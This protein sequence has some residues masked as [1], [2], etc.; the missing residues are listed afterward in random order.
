MLFLKDPYTEDRLRAMGLSERQI[1]AVAWLK[2]Q[3]RITNGDYQNL[4]G[5]SERTATRDL[6]DLVSRGVLEQTGTTGRGAGY[7][8]MPPERRQSR[9]NDATITPNG[10]QAA[11][12]G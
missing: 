11:P 2:K 10:S 12:H 7:V 6:S 4:S 1:K 8:L 9:Q 3:E 5:V